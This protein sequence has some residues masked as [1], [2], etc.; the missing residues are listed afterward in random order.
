MKRAMLLFLVV[1]V[2]FSCEERHDLQTNMSTNEICQ[3]VGKIIKRKLTGFY[4][5]NVMQCVIRSTGAKQF[6][7]TGDYVT[8][9]NITL[10]YTARGMLN[11]RIVLINEIKAHG[12]NKDFIPFH[13]FHLSSQ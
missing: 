1:F 6:E 8:P 3:I 12:V 4:K 9:D 13:T 5:V 7:I 11:D 2:L 10:L